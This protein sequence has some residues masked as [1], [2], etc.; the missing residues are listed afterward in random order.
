MRLSA[1]LLSVAAGTAVA[2]ASP[3][4]LSA[5]DWTAEQLEVW[6]FEQACWEMHASG[7]QDGLLDC[8]HDDY[9]GWHAGEPIP[10]TKQ[11]TRHWWDADAGTYESVWYLIKPVGIVVVDN[12]AVIH[13]YYHARIR[14]AD[15]AVEAVSGKVTEVLIKQDG[16]WFWIG[17]QTSNS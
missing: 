4:P 9:L 16:R 14:N 8:F 3:A 7:D 10:R 15:G 5:Q 2:L 1:I 17:D 12:V 11:D 13:L 6:E